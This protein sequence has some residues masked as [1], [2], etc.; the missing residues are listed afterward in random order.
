[1]GSDPGGETLTASFLEQA[2]ELARQGNAFVLATVVWRREPSSGRPG[3]KA[4][5]L[6]DGTVKGWLGGACAESTVIRESLE[7]LHTGEPRLLFFGVDG[8]HVPDGVTFV[9]MACADEGAIE[10]YLEPVVPKPQVI[11]IGRTPAVETLASL[12]RVLGWNPTI[13]DAGGSTLDH[14]TAVPVRTTLDLGTADSNTAIVVATQGHYYEQALEAALAT[15]AAYVGLVASARR[16]DSVRDLLRD[17]GIAET[18]LARVRAPAGL[19]L[20]SV[21]N[22]EIAVAVLA[23]LVSLRAAGIFHPAV[24]VGEGPAEAIDPVCGM[25][26]DVATAHHIA[27]HDGQTYY[28]C[29]AGCQRQFENNPTAFLAG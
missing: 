21:T 11:V 20:G 3:A 8:E 23:E 24:R 26:V 15:D 12:A 17:R 10:V 1:V 2:A 29:A 19:D 22:E 16:A 28:F 6:A 13:V 18:D 5:V 27:Q 4:L 25:T 7:A 14:T 9:P